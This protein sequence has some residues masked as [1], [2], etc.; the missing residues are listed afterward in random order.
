MSLMVEHTYAMLLVGVLL[1]LPMLALALLFSEG[2]GLVDTGCRFTLE[3]GHT[4]EKK[5]PTTQAN[6]NLKRTMSTRNGAQLSHQE[7]WLQWSPVQLDTLGLS[8]IRRSLIHTI[9]FPL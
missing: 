8:T 9:T 4:E 7:C 6:E 2:H 3:Q 5:I 1:V